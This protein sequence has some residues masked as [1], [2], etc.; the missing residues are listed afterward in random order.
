M[1]ALPSRMSTIDPQI[2]PG[3]ETGRVAEQEDGGASVLP[4]LAQLAQHVLRRP[5]GPPLGVLLEK[6]LDH[7]GDD[8]ARR[9]RVDPDAVLAPF[10]GQTP[11]EL[12][13]S[14]FGSVVGGTDQALVY[15]SGLL[16]RFCP[17]KADLEN[18]YPIGDSCTHACDHRNAPSV[19]ELD[20]LLG[21]GLRGHEDAGNVDVEHQVRV[22]GRVFQRGRFLLDAGSGDE[23]VHPSMRLRDGLDARV[24]LVDIPHV[25]LA[26]V[27]CRPELFCRALLYA[28]EVGGLVASVSRRGSMSTLRLGFL[29]ALAVDQVHT[30]WSRSLSLWSREGTWRR[31][32]TLKSNGELTGCARFQ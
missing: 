24:E 1:S 31:P 17:S 32:S 21:D 25:D 26:V 28:V 4:R 2:R 22:F 8:I 12:D 10:G 16:D 23:A 20:H 15:L 7:G 13:D 29:P 14:G 19:A 27:Q 30:L 5:L 6:L 3:H 9:Y 18:T 11:R